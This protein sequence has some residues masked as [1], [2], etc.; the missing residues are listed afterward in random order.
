MGRCASQGCR[1]WPLAGDQRSDPEMAATRGKVVGREG[2]P[3]R[4]VGAAG[5][6]GPNPQES[7]QRD[8]ELGRIRAAPTI[9]HG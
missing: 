4:K 5:W 1:T 2:H 6:G 3:F 8:N 9:V 7:R